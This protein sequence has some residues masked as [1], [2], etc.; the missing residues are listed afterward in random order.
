M[1]KGGFFSKLTASFKKSSTVNEPNLGKFAPEEKTPLDEKFV[2]QFT[3]GGG[4][5][6]YCTSK[7]DA[8]TALK[9]YCSEQHWSGA[10]ISSPNLAGWKNEITIN[11]TFE[12]DGQF[13]VVLSSCE[14]LIA[15]N[16]GI[17]IHDHHTGGRRL[18][19]LPEHHIL[20]AYTS[21]IV[22]NL[23]DGMTAINQKYRDDRPGN[24]AVIRAP[25]DQNVELAAAD[26]NKNRT[27]FLILIE[28]EA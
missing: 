25:H 9:H 11:S 23:R 1:A 14:A 28:D 21:Q 6:M 27:V 3:E 19:D 10:F 7:H 17:M 5:F 16:G 24:I 2:S 13:P 15:F 4:K 20:I 8:I 18:A 26:P 12:N 22:A